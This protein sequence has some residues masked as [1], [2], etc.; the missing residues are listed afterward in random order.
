MQACLFAF[1]C[2]RLDL[3]RKKEIV[4][5][6]MIADQCHLLECSFVLNK[7]ENTVHELSHFYGFCSLLHLEI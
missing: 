2:H 4:D 1:K 5:L 7:G 6:S 3:K